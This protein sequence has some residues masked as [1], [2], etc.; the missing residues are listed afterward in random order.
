[1]DRKPC[2]NGFYFM[3]SYLYKPVTMYHTRAHNKV[4]KQVV[5]LRT[6]AASHSKQ[7]K[8]FRDKAVT[9]E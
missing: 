7:H 3:D 2:N 4:F 5:K 1:M 9:K 6:A 8:R